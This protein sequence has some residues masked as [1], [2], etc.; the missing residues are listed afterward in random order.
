M[1]RDYYEVL[2][3]NR[4]AT[5]D[6]IKKA[7]RKLAR[8]YHP[9][10]NKDPAAEERFKEVSEAYD[11]LSDKQKRARYDQFGHASEDPGMG[12]GFGFDGFDI[13]EAFFG[14]ASRSRPRRRQA[15]RGADLQM[16]VELSF[17][18]AVFGTEKTVEV[19]RQ[20]TCKS[21]SGSGAK[22]GSKVDTCPVCHGAGQIQQVQRTLL[23]HF[24]HVTTCPKCDGEGKVVETPCPDCKGAGKTRAS[25]KLQVKIPGGVDTGAHLRISGEGDAGNQGGPPGDLYLVLYV[26]AH[27]RFVRKDLDILTFQPITFG[28]AALGSEVDVETL[29]GPR[30]LKIPAGTQYGTIF[31]LKGLG[32]PVLGDK[33]RGDLLVEVRI[34]VPTKLSEEQIELLKRFEETGEETQ[35]TGFLGKIKSALGKH[36]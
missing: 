36:S 21:C 17:E 10:V 35:G 2:E 24:T 20:E 5:D 29:D 13:F 28:Q 12:G 31:P 19:H 23:G 18:E 32:M 6:E 16:E 15:Q 14:G 30:K 27:E 25:K 33:R 3:V 22:A 1:K 34:G 7:Y 11:V 9:D 26:R 8:Q 4:Q